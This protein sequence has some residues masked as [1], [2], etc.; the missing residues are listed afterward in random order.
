MTNEII[1]FKKSEKRIIGTSKEMRKFR[2]LSS[3]YLVHN[4]IAESFCEKKL[5]CFDPS[6]WEI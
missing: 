1:V 3:G 5:R 4:E 2:I 6:S